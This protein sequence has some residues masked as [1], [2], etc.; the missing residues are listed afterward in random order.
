[1]YSKHDF[2][3]TYRPGLN[4]T[5]EE[6]NAKPAGKYC[7]QMKCAEYWQDYTMFS[8]FMSS[9]FLLYALIHVNKSDCA[10]WNICSF[11]PLKQRSWVQFSIMAW[12]NVHVFSCNHT[13]EECLLNLFHLLI[14]THVTTWEQL[15]WVSLILIFGTFLVTFVSTFQFWLKSDNNNGP[16]MWRAT[17][18]SAHWSD[19][20]G[21]LDATLVTMVTLIT[22]IT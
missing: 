5:Y 16:F 13:P 7:R 20:V 14:C 15:N 8:I 19:W 11:I 21:N 9:P 6:D 3:V 17:R 2:S 4:V 22:M 10:T 1:M 18:V 12:M